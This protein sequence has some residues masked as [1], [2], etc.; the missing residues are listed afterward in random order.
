DHVGQRLP[1][2]R[3]QLP[4][5]ARGA[6]VDVRGR[7][8]RGSATD[9]GR[10]RGRVVRVRPRRAGAHRGARRPQGGRRGS[11]PRPSAEGLHPVPGVRRGPSHGTYRGGRMTKVRYGARSEEERRNREIEATSVGVWAKTLVATY[12]TDPEVVAAVLPQPLEPTADPFVRVTI[13]SVEIG[14]RP[15]F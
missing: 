9:G 10:Q 8:A 12:E 15:P 1:P 7:G 6:A 13:A 5:L 11:T 2:P 14:G 4:V 3:G